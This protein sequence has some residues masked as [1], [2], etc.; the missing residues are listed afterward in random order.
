MPSVNL[1]IEPVTAAEIDKDIGRRL[2]H[3]NQEF[4]KGFNF[5]KKYPKSVT[6][7]GSARLKPGNK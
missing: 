3:I 4:Q 7:F 5:I 2:S 1:P 6:F